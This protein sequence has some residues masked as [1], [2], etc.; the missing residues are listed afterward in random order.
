MK[1]LGIPAASLHTWRHTFASYIMM[2]SGNIRAVQKLL[3]HRSIR[4]TEV[5]AHLSELHLQNVV[6]MLP[7]PNLGAPVVLPGRGI[8]QTPR[9]PR[10][11]YL[12][13]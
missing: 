1:R 8:V 7:G 9:C 3:G 6:G 2:R 13:Y 10:D 5:Y 4:T 12:G 11:S